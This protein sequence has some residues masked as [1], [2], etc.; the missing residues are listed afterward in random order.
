MSSLSTYRDVEI[1]A[2][3]GSLPLDEITPE[4]IYVLRGLAGDIARLSRVS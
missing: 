1:A 3:E 2:S 4:N